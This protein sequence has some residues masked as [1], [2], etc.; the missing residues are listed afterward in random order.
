MTTFQQKSAH[1]RPLEAQFAVDVIRENGNL[2][3]KGADL[4]ELEGIV[5]NKYYQITLH[6][7]LKELTILLK[8]Q[9]FTNMC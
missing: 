7:I 6:I 9:C 8:G 1:P 4:G 5:V 2:D 3:G